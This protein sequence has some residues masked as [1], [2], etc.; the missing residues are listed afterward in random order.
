[1]QIGDQAQQASLD[2]AESSRQA[3]WQYASFVAELFKGFF[4]W[5]LISPYPLQEKTD[6]DKGDSFL[7]H[8]E[9]D[10][11][12]HIDPAQVDQTQNIPQER[13]QALAKEGYFG[14]KIDKEHG[15]LGL[16]VQNYARAME[17]TG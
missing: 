2:L 13:I 12:T 4:R 15:G 16:S 1:M 17:M 14:M 7:Q 10:L 8:L 3:E 11:K 6:K 9:A 5:D